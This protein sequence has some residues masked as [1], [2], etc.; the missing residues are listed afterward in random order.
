MGYNTDVIISGEFRFEI[1]EV[2]NQIIKA[3]GTEP[4][5][6]AME[7]YIYD[8]W[9]VVACEVHGDAQERVLDFL[10]P[11]AKQVPDIVFM[12]DGDGDETWDLWRMYIKGDKS[13][14]ISL[15]IDPEFDES[16]LHDRSLEDTK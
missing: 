10:L 9:W 6:Y 8:D 2:G 3:I 16:K 5:F 7:H 12:V 4:Y 14:A 11:F 15:V 13:Y 1:G